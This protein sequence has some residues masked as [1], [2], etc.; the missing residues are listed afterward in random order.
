MIS[1]T[2]DEMR[3]MIESEVIEEC[4][5]HIQLHHFERSTVPDWAA[6]DIPI[7]IYPIFRS[8]YIRGNQG[9][10]HKTATG[11]GKLGKARRRLALMVLVHWHMHPLHQ[12]PPCQ[13]A[14]IPAWPFGRDFRCSG[15]RGEATRLSFAL[16]I[17]KARVFGKG[18]RWRRG[19]VEMSGRAV[20]GGAYVSRPAS[21]GA[22]TDKSL[23]TYPGEPT[24]PGLASVASIVPTGP[25]DAAP[26]V[27]P[28]LPLSASITLP[29]RGF[30]VRL[31]IM[32]L[33]PPR[34]G[35]VV[36][37][38]SFVYLE[39]LPSRVR[40]V[41]RGRLSR[42]RLDFCCFIS[43]ESSPSPFSQRRGEGEKGI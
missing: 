23:D 32:V 18:A 8:R 16:I 22:T 4:V 15:S 1:H 31:L 29:G 27:S 39:G 25:A 20:G 24:C 40:A 13:G 9:R 30:L 10:K 19:P 37:R 38:A 5:R 3:I 26:L 17:R 2:W 21:G 14:P 34:R 35:R 6:M 28:P 42:V 11:Q 7:L 43:V 12:A 36:F 33:D 41:R